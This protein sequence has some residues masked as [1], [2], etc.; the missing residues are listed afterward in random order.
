MQV[1]AEGSV[2][3]HNALPCTRV[4][5]TAILQGLRMDLSNYLP[6]KIGQKMLGTVLTDS[7]SV[8]TVRYCI[9]WQVLTV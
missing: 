2:M 3:H 1:A 6:P 7:L 8:L 5:Y 4:H 9:Y